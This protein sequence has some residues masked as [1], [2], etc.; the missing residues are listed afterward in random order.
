MW[1]FFLFFPFWSEIIT[2][3]CQQQQ[4]ATKYKEQRN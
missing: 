4:T 2:V 1:A 3:T